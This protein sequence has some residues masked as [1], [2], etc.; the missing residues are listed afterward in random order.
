VH[1]LTQIQP[2]HLTQFSRINCRDFSRINF[3]DL[4]LIN[5]SDFI[6]NTFNLKCIFHSNTHNNNANKLHGTKLKCKSWK[7]YTL[8]K[9]EPVILC[10]VGGD[11]DHHVYHAARGQLC[12][13]VKHFSCLNLG[14]YIILRLQ[15]GIPLTPNNYINTKYPHNRYTKCPLNMY[16]KCPL[17]MYTKCPYIK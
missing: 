1:P 15:L 13:P 5:W 14:R 9:F 7:P 8:A 6:I 12:Y 10:T 2:Y 3:S 17:N 4:S 16:T 11:D